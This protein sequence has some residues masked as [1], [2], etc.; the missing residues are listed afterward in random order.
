[1]NPGPVASRLLH[2]L[3]SFS[4]TVSPPKT[5]SEGKAHGVFGQ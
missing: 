4:N 1:M 2:T 3:L 5:G